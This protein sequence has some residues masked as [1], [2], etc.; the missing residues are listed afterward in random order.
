MA[1]WHVRDFT[2]D[3]LAA[4]VRLDA[5]SATT[6]RAAVFRL[7][8]VVVAL[9]ARNPSV[10]VVANGHLPQRRPSAG[11][12]GQGRPGGHIEYTADSG[13]GTVR[14]IGRLDL[15]P[16]YLQAWCHL[17]DDERVFPSPASTE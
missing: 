15:D 7:S 2:P 16:P 14:T 10:V 5:E 6:D 1:V 4:V 13:S 3:D 12:R 9:Q 17:R 11:P 8:D